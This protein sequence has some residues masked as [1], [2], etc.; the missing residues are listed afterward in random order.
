MSAAE[1]GAIFARRDALPVERSATH[2]AISVAHSADEIERMACERG[3]DFFICDRGGHFHVAEVWVENAWLVEV[4]TPEFAAEYLTF[5][6]GI[7]ELSNPD[8]ALS[9]HQPNAKTLELL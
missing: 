4:L 6:Q 9:A 2:F 3:W 8:D 1:D 7:F 5:S